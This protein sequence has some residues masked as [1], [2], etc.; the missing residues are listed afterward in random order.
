MKTA[1]EKILSRASGGEASA[2][3]IVEAE[4]DVYMI[5][6]PMGALVEDALDEIGAEVKHPEKVVAI[7]D[8][9]VPA[10]DIESAILSKR[11]REFHLRFNFGAYYEVGRGGICHVVMPE[12]GHVVPG[13][14]IVGTDSHTPTSG[15]LGAFSVGIG[16]TEMA[17]AMALGKLWFKVPPTILVK[18]EG[19][20]REFVHAKDFI[21]QVISEIGTDGAIYKAIEFD[22]PTIR[23]LNMD[24]R[25]VLTNMS[26]EAGAKTGFISPDNLTFQYLESRARR[27]PRPEYSD[28]GSFE[29]ELLFDVSSLDPLVAAPHSPANVR[30]A[31][32][33]DE[34]IDQAFIG[35]CTGGRLSD[36]KAAVKILRGRKISDRVRLIVIPSSRRV[37]REAL[38]MG[39]LE[40]LVESGAAIGP[41]SC[42]PCLGAHLGVL[43]PGE[44]GIS[45]SNRNFRGRMGHPDSRVYLASPSTVAASAFTGRV[46]DPR[47]VS[48]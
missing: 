44:V 40:S 27:N 34:E 24:E 41:P 8:H 12:E 11:L 23:E 29:D 38:R 17:A 13:D 45:S 26:V 22:G 43:G 30:A 28:K 42:G 37:Y 4:I 35:S 39:F 5:H 32:E 2:G 25:F 46:T 3:D 18:G 9:F 7:Q 48:I 47:E 14:V 21:L 1:V 31:S 10:K 19:S 15:A 20:F 16:A 6:D 36:L 33:V